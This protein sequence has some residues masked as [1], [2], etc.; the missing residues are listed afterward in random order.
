MVRNGERE[1]RLIGLDLRFPRFVRS[2]SRRRLLENVHPAPRDGPPNQDCIVQVGQE[3]GGIARGAPS[4]VSEGRGQRRGR[5]EVLDHLQDAHVHETSGKDGWAHQGLPQ[6]A[7]NHIPDLCFLEEE[8]DPPVAQNLVP[9]LDRQRQ[10][11][12]SRDG[13]GSGRVSR[14][15]VGSGVL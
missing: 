4:G 10:A 3:K 13:S 11:L 2:V 12:G 15:S 7:E 8:R 9:R 1:R 14:A 6:F 5:P